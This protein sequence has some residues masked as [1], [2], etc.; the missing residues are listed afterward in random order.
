MAKIS[1]RELAKV[2]AKKHK[3]SQKAAENFVTMLFDVVNEGLETEKSVKVKGLG[4]FKV[5]TVKSRESINV[6]TGERVL[7]DGHDK[8]SFTPDAV[9]RDFINKPFAQFETVLINDG[10]DFSGIDAQHADEL[11]EEEEANNVDSFEPTGSSALASTVET[12]VSDVEIPATS[13]TVAP[14][15]EIPADVEDEPAIEKD[16]TTDETPAVEEDQTTYEASAG[17]EQTTID[18][19]IFIKTNPSVD[20]KPSVEDE[21]PVEEVNLIKPRTPEQRDQHEAFKEQLAALAITGAAPS[22]APNKP[23]ETN[24]ESQQSSHSH[25]NHSHHNHSHHSHHN[26]RSSDIWDL[27]GQLEEARKKNRFTMLVACVLVFVA[28]G[29]GYLLGRNYFSPIGKKNAVAQQ[30]DTTASATKNYPLPQVASES[31]QS[32]GKS[33]SAPLPA[34]SPSTGSASLV[35]WNADSRIRYGAYEIV[36]I[37]TIVTLRQGQT[38]MGVCRATIG[39][40]L[41][42]YMQVVNDS[43]TLKSGR[44]KVPKLAVRKKK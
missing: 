27:E 7:I 5:A 38:M 2:I 44:V 3:M 40:E 1:V 42:G 36:G 8:V 11:V 23:S 26:R 19:D 31:S 9:M 28:L 30:V 10:V 13:V 15:V 12:T 34:S 24:A 18:E 32:A 39:A 6:N 14:V 41:I 17:D 21:S 37:D 29:F 20:V 4:T 35:Q 16:L 25:H 22:S 33:I 43:A